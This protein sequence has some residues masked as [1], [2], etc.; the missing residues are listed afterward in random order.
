M[1]CSNIHSIFLKTLKTNAVIFFIKTC[2][3]WQATYETHSYTFST[4]IS[5]NTLKTFSN[6]HVHSLTNAYLLKTTTSHSPVH[7]T[8]PLL[9]LY[10]VLLYVSFLSH[11]MWAVSAVDTSH[12]SDEMLDCN[13]MRQWSVTTNKLASL[14]SF[15]SDHILTIYLNEV[16]SSYLPISHT[17][18]FPMQF[19]L[20]QLHIWPV[21]TPLTDFTNETILHD[22]QT[23]S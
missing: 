18:K 3:Y 23:I 1:P 11:Y 15:S 2:T 13:W 22:I 20:L 16:W 5:G 4:Y 6:N 21:T 14:S 8:Q 19:P 17:P 12:K 7:H 10:Y 9:Q